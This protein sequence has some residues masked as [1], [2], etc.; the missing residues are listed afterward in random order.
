MFFRSMFYMPYIVPFVAAV[1]LW[2]GMLNSEIRLD[3]SLPFMGRHAKGK[4][5]A[6]GE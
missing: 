6:L 3:Q 4:C 5:T 1:F 2:G